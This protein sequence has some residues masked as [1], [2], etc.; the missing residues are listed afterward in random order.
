MDGYSISEVAERTGFTASALRFYEQH[1][2]VRPDRTRS[3]YRSYDDRHVQL[4]GF[5]SRAKGFGLSLEEITELLEL[6][7][8]DR[9][10]PVQDRLRGLID[11]KIGEAEAR[12]A[13]LIA[14]TAELRRVASTLDG[15]TPDGP[16]DD[17]CGCVT[18]PLGVEPDE[19]VT[20]A[21][22]LAPNEMGPRL[23]AWQAMAEQSTGRHR[24][25]DGVHVRFP[26]SVD[27]G[28]LAALVAAEQA[29]CRFFTFTLTVADAEV[30][31]EIDAPPDGGA[32]VDALLSGEP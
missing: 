2:L 32:L 19:H 20:I 18:D 4:L 29:C 22:T 1:G 14:F 24:V 31:L 12:V 15:A 30:V 3:G 7:R 5:I 8:Q 26:R 13:E 11:A 27:V 10:S 23:A 25:A 6:L 16:C 21:C 28:A 9:C 17:T